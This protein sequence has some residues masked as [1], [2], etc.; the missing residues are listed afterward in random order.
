[1]PKSLIGLAALTQ[2]LEPSHEKYK[3]VDLSYTNLTA[4]FGG[5]KYFDKQLREFKP[6]YPHAILHDVCLKQNGVYF[7]MDSILITPSFIII[8]EVKNISGKLIFYKDPDR[9]IRVDSQG[10]MTSMQSPVA[11]LKRKIYFLREWLNKRE[12]E[13][14]IEG[15]VVLA[16]AKEVE[17]VTVPDIHITFAYQVSTYLY[18]KSLGK[19]WISKS[20]LMK[21]ANEMKGRHEEY[22]P[23]PMIEKWKIERDAILPGVICIQCGYRGMKWHSRIW[24]CPQCRDTGLK[25]HKNAVS[26]WFYLIGKRMTNEE[27]RAFLLVENRHIAKRMLAKSNVQI[28]GRGRGRHYLLMEPEDHD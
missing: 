7:Q 3:G 23:F 27:F 21:L 19:E 16:Y 10:E 13:I 4:G 14:P 8:F 26:D 20:I 1:M 2:R 6:S 12:I 11:Q 15:V 17:A 22:S 28:Q 24:V 25:N 9:L 5:E 18:E